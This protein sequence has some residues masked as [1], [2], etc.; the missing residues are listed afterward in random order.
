MQ[1]DSSFFCMHGRAASC[2]EMPASCSKGK[3]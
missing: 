1:G 2:G 3:C